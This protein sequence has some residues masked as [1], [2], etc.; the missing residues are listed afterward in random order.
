MTAKKVV[1]QILLVLV[2][3]AIGGAGAWYWLAKGGGH[4]P[5][6]AGKGEAVEAMKQQYTCA[7]HPF[8]LSDKP[9][10]CP[11]CGMTLVPVRSDSAAATGSGGEKKDRKILFYRNPMNPGVTSPVP[12]KDNMGMDYVPVY[13]GEGGEEGTIRVEEVLPDSPGARA[14]IR[15][16]E[17]IVEIGS[18]FADG[19]SIDEAVQLGD[20]LRRAPGVRTH[21]DDLL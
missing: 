21:P 12:A 10:D 17:R 7:M 11:I 14:G 8:V 19:V 3:A 13:E 4:V 2:A 18:R 15:A 9:G 5:P 6:A 20:V 1:T 16:G